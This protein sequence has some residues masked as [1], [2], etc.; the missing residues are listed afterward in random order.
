MSTNEESTQS[1]EKI[2]IY[3]TERLFV[4]NAE[5]FE[6]GTLNITPCCDKMIP[7]THTI[8]TLVKQTHTQI[9]I[10]KYQGQ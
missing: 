6:T 2:S 3:S 1:L 8:F 4:D 9:T 5:V 10:S 7:Q